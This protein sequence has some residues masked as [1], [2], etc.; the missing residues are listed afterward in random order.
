MVKGCNTQL[1]LTSPKELAPAICISRESQVYSGVSYNRY[2][3][4]FFYSYAT[5]HG[6]EKCNLFEHSGCEQDSLSMR[7]L[8]ISHGHGVN[9]F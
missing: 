9:Y 5:I 1:F 6:I 2:E 7:F 4:Y 8:E 3:N